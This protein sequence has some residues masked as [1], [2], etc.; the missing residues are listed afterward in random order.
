MGWNFGLDNFKRGR[1]MFFLFGGENIYNFDSL[2]VEV[3]AEPNIEVEVQ[4]DVEI[5]IEVII[6]ESS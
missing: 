5:Q 6:N 4:K 3:S 1:L 2:E